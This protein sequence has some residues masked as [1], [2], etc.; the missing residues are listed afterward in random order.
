MVV[1]SHRTPLETR[2]VLERRRD[3]Q[4]SML[5]QTNAFNLSANF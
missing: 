1:K 2:H 4:V 5:F 3:C